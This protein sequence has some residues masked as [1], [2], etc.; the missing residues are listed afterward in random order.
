MMYLILAIILAVGIAVAVQRAQLSKE[1]KTARIL[2]QESLDAL[3]AD[4]ENNRLR[5]AALARGRDYAEVA[6][7]AAGSNGVA[8]FDEVALSN[9][10]TARLGSKNG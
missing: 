6:R 4:S 2:Y 8:I 3:G 9:D 5:Q 10:I 7:R 1:L